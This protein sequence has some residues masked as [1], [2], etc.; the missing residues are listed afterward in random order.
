MEVYMRM[1]VEL[2]SFM[3]VSAAASS[4]RSLYRTR[5]ARGTHWVGRYGEGKNDFSF[6]RIEP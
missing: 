6:P 2:H 4:Y 3:E 5:K 1:K